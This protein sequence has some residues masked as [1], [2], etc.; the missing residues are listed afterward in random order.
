MPGNISAPATDRLLTNHSHCSYVA[1]SSLSPPFL[2]MRTLQTLAFAALRV[3]ALLA[4]SRRSTALALTFIV[5]VL[6]VYPFLA[7]IVCALTVPLSTPTES[8][9]ST[10]ARIPFNK[11]VMTPSGFEDL[12]F[13]AHCSF[14][15][16]L[17]PTQTSAYVQPPLSHVLILTIVSGVSHCSLDGHSE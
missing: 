17:S 3:Y 11:Q 16:M 1:S 14:T 2:D 12:S 4:G 7:T 5:A 15:S 10:Q 8:Q 13:T 6:N 9:L